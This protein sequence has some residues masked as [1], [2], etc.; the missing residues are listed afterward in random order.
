MGSVPVGY[1]ALK[2]KGVDIRRVGSGNIGATNVYRTSGGKRAILVLLADMLKGSAPVGIASFFLDSPTVL[3]SVAVASV[4]GHMFP[5]F[6]NFQGGKGVATSAGA[7]MI[8]SP[9]ALAPAFIAWLGMLLSSWYVS[10]ASLVAAAT[11]FL[12]AIAFNEHWAIISAA[13]FTALLVAVKHKENIRRLR[14]GKEPRIR[15][16]Q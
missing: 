16:Q 1:L 15:R 11:L 10:L 4:I 6:L 9:Q 5:V 8:L 14:S 2:R 3:A 12:A 13:F 7:F